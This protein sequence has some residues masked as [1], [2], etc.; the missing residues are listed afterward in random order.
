MKIFHGGI[1]LTDWEDY[2]AQGVTVNGQLVYEKVDII[3][4]AA[5]RFFS[6]GN[7]SGS[8]QFAASRKFDT[9][10]DAQVFILTHFSLLPEVAMTE[11]IC[12]GG[13]EDPQSVYFLNAVLSGSP[14]GI[15]E[16]LMVVVQYTI[17]FGTVT[18]EF[19]PEFL[20]GDPDVVIKRGQEAIGSAAESGAVVFAEAFPA[21]HVP[22]VIATVAKP[23][24]SGS[25][26]FATIRDDLTS[27]L[28]FTYELD[29]PTPDENHKLNWIA[30][31]T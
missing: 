17:E 11:I 18:T 23:S 4:A 5:A 3:R 12:G 6:R 7:K 19:P 25:N 15:Y 16:G 29:G 24:G 28:G 14:Q 20:I 22:I 13:G 2:P 9:L 31:E 1:Q 30:Y 26:I 10:K 8:L 27:E 21:G